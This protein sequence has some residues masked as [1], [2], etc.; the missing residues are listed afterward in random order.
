VIAAA[1]AITVL[2]V[3]WLL[4][5]ERSNSPARR[6]A[7][8][9]ASAGFIA[10]ALAAGAAESAFGRWVLVALVLSAIGDV[11]LLE[12]RGFLAGL[13]S[14]LAAHVAYSVAFLVRGIAAPGLAAAVPLGVFGWLVVRWLWPHLPDS[15]PGW[16]ADAS[17][18]PPSAT[19][20]PQAFD[21]SRG[22]NRMRAPVAAY[23]VAISVM[24][25]LAVATAADDWD[26][27]IPSGAL[28]FIVSDVAVARQTFVHSSFAN[29]LWGLPLY[30]S[31]QLLLAWAAG[32]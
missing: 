32:G 3:A 22:R 21:P 11:L 25:V 10:V 7:K 20:N 9:L 19:A 5:A 17:P 18:L 27:R 15:H 30:Y 1:A 8:P 26:W 13:A 24:G 23:A 14:F 6:V 28:I 29:R 31:G 16:G 12:E 2:G 4:A